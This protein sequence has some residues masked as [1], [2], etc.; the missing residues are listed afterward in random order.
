MSLIFFCETKQHLVW[1]ISSQP[2]YLL[3][4][5]SKWWVNSWWLF[6]CERFL[7]PFPM[8]PW[9]WEWDAPG[10]EARG[11][12][13]TPFLLWHCDPSLH[14]GDR[15]IIRKPKKRKRKYVETGF[16]KFTLIEYCISSQK[17]EI[18]CCNCLASRFINCLCFQM[19]P[20]DLTHNT[21]RQDVWC[22]APRWLE[23]WFGP[24]MNPEWKLT[25]TLISQ[26]LTE[27]SSPNL[28]F[29]FFYFVHFKHLLWV[30]SIFNQWLYFYL[31]IFFITDSLVSIAD[32]VLLSLQSLP[33]ND[34]LHVQICF[35]L[36]QNCDSALKF[37]A[38]CTN[39]LLPEFRFF[40]SS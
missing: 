35:A 37:A 11:S 24:A 29:V 8:L 30:I 16:C 3:I 12:E 25:L 21:I 22:K 1:R 27:G 13:D 14:L 34:F 4:M 2:L 31:L 7:S 9:D 32:D 19:N 23:M 20:T 15:R 28:F 39:V 5:K 26:F 18:M 17:A 33:S 38:A 36:Y 10:E 6:E 40:F